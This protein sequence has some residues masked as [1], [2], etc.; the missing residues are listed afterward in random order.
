MSLYKQRFEG[1]EAL[2]RQAAADKDGH[3][4]LAA[5]VTLACRLVLTRTEIGVGG[6][7]TRGT[8][9]PAAVETARKLAVPWARQTIADST[10][11]PGW[12]ASAG[13]HLMYWERRLRKALG[14]PVDLMDPATRTAFLESWLAVME[15]PRPRQLPSD[16]AV[17]LLE[18]EDR[19]AAL[20]GW[21]ALLKRIKTLP[22]KN[23]PWSESNLSGPTALKRLG[24]GAGPEPTKDGA[25]L[26]ISEG[27]ERIERA[28]TE[29]ERMKAAQE[30]MER[31]KARKQ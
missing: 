27:I 7:P 26:E 4:E 11:A 6:T 8:G 1:A 17:L 21:K 19:L 2:L 31:M 5:T 23:R 28:K 10:A 13:K 12:R 14:K 9:D 22:G 29:E 25:P 3:P 30:M 24:T 18:Q 16:T 15:D 20:P